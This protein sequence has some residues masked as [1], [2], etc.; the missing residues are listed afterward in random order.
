MK[1]WPIVVSDHARADIIAIFEYIARDNGINADK[2]MYRLEERVRS[3]DRFPE[4]GRAVPEL[5]W[6]G[7]MNVHEI[8]EKPWRI[9]YRIDDDKVVV[10]AVFDGRRR[11]DDMVVERFLG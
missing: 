11:L 8:F 6:H 3:L 5:Q 7:L 4:R 10:I 1:S 2:A 9:I